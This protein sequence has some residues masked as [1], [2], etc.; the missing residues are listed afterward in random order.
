M[1]QLLLAVFSIAVAATSFAQNQD[2]DPKAKAIL[3]EIS[4]KTKEYKTISVDFVTIIKGRDINETRKGQAIVKGDKFY[5]ESADQ[6][7][8]C[9]GKSVWNYTS[10]ENECYVEK[11]SNIDDELNPSKMLTI[12]ES[13]FK[14]QF[15]KET[16]ENG[17]VIQEIKLFPKDAQK[18]KYHTIIL[19]IDKAKKEVQKVSIKGKDGLDMTFEIKKFETNKEIPD[20]TFVFEKTKFPGV[21]VIDNR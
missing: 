4:K 20:N 11:L 16:T 18:T 1:K 15:V 10:E 7:V 21:D 2:Q 9:D 14:F 8:F 13:G 12:W 5:Y 3:D 17:K 6:K 19:K